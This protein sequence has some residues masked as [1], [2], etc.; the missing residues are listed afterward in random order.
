[1]KPGSAGDQVGIVGS[2]G[3]GPGVF[4][5]ELISQVL[6]LIGWIPI[7]ILYGI[8]DGA[9][10]SVSQPLR[11]VLVVRTEQ[12]YVAAFVHHYEADVG[13]VDLLQVHAGLIDS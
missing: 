3:D 1:M 7:D 8:N 2:V 5:A 10:R 6:D 11:L 4:V 13:S 12:Y 9:G